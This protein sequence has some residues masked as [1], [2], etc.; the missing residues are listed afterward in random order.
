[1][2]EVEAQPVRSHEGTLLTNVI[3]QDGAQSGVQEVRRGVIPT[4]GLTPLGVDGRHR[5][6]AGQQFSGEESA[7]GEEPA[8]D[9]LDVEDLEAAR[10]GHDHPGV[11]D[12]PPGLRV[13]GRRVEEELADAVLTD[14]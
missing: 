11:G 9:V 14:E 6:L 3:T 2:G 13:E 5:D 7:M 1:M 4:R 12:L 8:G 10:L